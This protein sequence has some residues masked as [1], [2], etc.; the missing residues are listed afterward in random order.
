[1]S[2]PGRDPLY[3]FGYIDVDP[4]L[5]INDIV[6]AYKGKV[7]TP[8]PIIPINENDEVYLTLTNVGF[9]MR[10]DLD[11]AHTVHW[12]GFRNPT[13]YFDGV[14]EASVS[15]PQGRD[16]PYYY[17]PEHPGT[18]MY[19]CHFED[20][21]HVQ[22]GMDGII[23]VRPSQ[24]ATGTT[25]GHPPGKYVYNDGDGSTAY[26]REVTLLLNEIDTRPHDQLLNVQEFVWSDYKPNYWI[27]NGRSYPD[28]VLPNNDP[29]LPYQP[30]SSLVQCNPGD[31]V[32][33]RL[34]NLG[35]AQHSMQL[36]GI[37][38]KVVGHDATLLR[39][40]SGADLTYYT[41][42]LLIA[43]G[44]ARDVI[45]EAPA[46]DGAAATET[47][48]AGTYNVYYFKNRNYFAQTNNGMPGLGGMVTEI[49]VYQGSPLPAQSVD[50]PNETYL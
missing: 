32:L 6:S 8:S 5:P 41:N 50:D 9:E 25:G 48:A 38:M 14:P 40:T 4:N 31:R 37:P 18:Y 10:P 3:V 43:P 27:I 47:D 12:H 35:Y 42:S 1:M 36:P 2:L 29:S 45:I 21:E 13:A 33:L 28:T 24:N 23:Y 46:F 34:A 16:F 7:Q 49:R 30:I 22:M 39:S 26:D 11:D 19:H 20:V 17:R 44:E 15:V